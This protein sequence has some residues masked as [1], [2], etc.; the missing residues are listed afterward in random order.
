M[1]LEVCKE[2]KKHHVFFDNFFASYKL[3]NELNTI[4]F[5]ATGT[6]RENRSMKCP[7]M[8]VAE[9][10]KNERGFYDYR[11]SGNISGVMWNNNSVVTLCSNAIG[12]HP[13]RNAKHWIRGK[14]QVNFQPAMVGIYNSGMARVDLADR[15]L[16][17]YRP[18]FRGKKCIGL[19]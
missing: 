14:G 11:S 16:S 2:P 8:R 3:V 19:C 7:A 4:G 15:A 9:V 13:I 6:M 17:K 18:K 5:S 10:K 1:H 12:V